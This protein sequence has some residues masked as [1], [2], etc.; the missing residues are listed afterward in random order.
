[1]TMVWMEE[2]LLSFFFFVSTVG[3]Q[4]EGALPP[5]G[6]EVPHSSLVEDKLGRN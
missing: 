6:L 2:V 5:P 4:L 3:N 1:M